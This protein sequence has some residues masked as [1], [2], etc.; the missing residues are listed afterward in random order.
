MKLR[1][2]TAAVTLLSLGVFG[3]ASADEPLSLTD[4]A[5]LAL[6][7]NPEIMQAIQNR[8]AI[9]FEQRQARGLFYPRVWA[10]ASAGLRQLDNRSRRI[11]GL[12]DHTLYPMEFALYGEYTIFDS[13]GRQGELE[14]QA[15]RLDGASSRVAE[16][17]EYIALEV[18]RE[19]INYGLQ[20]R[21]VELARQNV[22]FHRDIVDRL[23]RGEVGGVISGADVNQARERYA[24]AQRRLTEAERERTRSVISFRRLVGMPVTSYMSPEAYL[25][26]LPGSLE[27]A[28]G[29]ARDNNPELDIAE[30]AIAAAEGLVRTARSEYLPTL[31][32]EG[33]ART[34]EDLDAIDGETNDVQVRVV[35]RWE[36][37]N[38]GIYSASEQEQL[39]R[40]SEERFRLHQVSREVEEDVRISWDRLESETTLMEVLG[41][42]TAL[43]AEVVD[44]YNRQWGTGQRSL[45]DLLDSQNTRINVEEAYATSQHAHLFAQYRLLAS[46][47]SLVETLGLTPPSAVETG[48]H[49]AIGGPD[50]GPGEED[51][52][53]YP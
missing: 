1:T 20:E 33:R 18:S 27:D 13:F 38:G 44:G 35:A 7:T 23:D 41:Q 52:R 36:L 26:D 53:R 25:E 16:R 12:D 40:V 17:A 51:Y 49:S 39:R 9:A 11:V 43:S 22:A 4:A 19:Y 37:Y 2:L 24:A 45:L 6:T 48:A 46:M 10:E 31:S 32:L 21:I 34:G 28:I 14:R 8:E 15:G 42:Q 3:A 29:M 5:Q 30:A 47:G 50:I